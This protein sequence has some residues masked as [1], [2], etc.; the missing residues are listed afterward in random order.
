MA[1]WKFDLTQYDSVWK[2][3]VNI[4]LLLIALL[5]GNALRRK[6]PFLRRAFIPSALI[7]GLLLFIANLIT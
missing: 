2:T 4:G 7:G 3:S 1:E 6:I 5:I